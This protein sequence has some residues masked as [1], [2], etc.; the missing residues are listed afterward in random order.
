MTGTDLKMLR[1]ALGISQVELGRRLGYPNPGIRI[2]EFEHGRRTVPKRVIA[3][4]LSEAESQQLSEDL[5]NQ[6]PETRAQNP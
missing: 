6:A 5:P 1:E 4:F 2:S 3:Y